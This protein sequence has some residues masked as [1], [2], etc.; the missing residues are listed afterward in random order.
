MP[1]PYD[2]I[3]RSG[4]PAG[5]RSFSAVPRPKRYR[6]TSGE[7]LTRTQV[8]VREAGEVS[9]FAVVGFAA[10]AVFAALLITSLRPVRDRPNEEVVIPSERPQTTLQAENATLSAQYE[11]VFDM[12]RSRP[13]WERHYGAAHQRSRSSTSDLSEP[14]SVVLYGE[15]GDRLRRHQSARC[16]RFKNIVGMS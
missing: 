2:G 15:A 16:R 10:V 6:R 3:C 11:Q 5:R 12:E 14:D 7:Q 13:P 9:P 8:Q 1:L 4:L